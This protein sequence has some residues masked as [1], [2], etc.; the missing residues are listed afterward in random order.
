MLLEICEEI[1]AYSAR[2][3]HRIR[4]FLI[5][6]GESMANLQG[7]LAGQSDSVSIGQETPDG[8]VVSVTKAH[9]NFMFFFKMYCSH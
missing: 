7:T 5:R 3:A 2:D 1:D 4:L 9:S 6:H 8:K